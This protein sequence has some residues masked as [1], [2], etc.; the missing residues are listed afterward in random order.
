[1]GRGDAGDLGGTFPTAKYS[2]E[3]KAQRVASWHRFLNLMSPIDGYLGIPSGVSYGSKPDG[4]YPFKATA[5]QSS[6][7]VEFDAGDGTLNEAKVSDMIYVT[8]ENV[9][10]G[11]FPVLPEND[12]IG[13]PYYNSDDPS[14]QYYSHVDHRAVHQALWNNDFGLPGHQYGRTSHGDP[15][16]GLIASIST[17]TYQLFTGVDSGSCQRTG[18][19]QRAYGWVACSLPGNMNGCPGSWDRAEQDS[20]AIF[21][22]VQHWWFRF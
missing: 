6:A 22:R 16:R 19:L 4:S 1:M 18:A 5:G 21:S 2:P 15:D 17:S 12:I 9:A 10:P 13:T 11:R 3:L 14:A 7:R 8:R 20:Q